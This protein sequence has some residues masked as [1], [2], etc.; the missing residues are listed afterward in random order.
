MLN[1]MCS[2]AAHMLFKMSAEIETHK[3]SQRN[4]RKPETKQQQ[5]TNHLLYSFP[6]FPE[7]ITKKRRSTCAYTVI[8][9]PYNY[10]H[11]CMTSTGNKFVVTPLLVQ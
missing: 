2:R 10:V 5:P 7:T 4:S 8:M 1:L 9:Y 11:I 3:P 6:I